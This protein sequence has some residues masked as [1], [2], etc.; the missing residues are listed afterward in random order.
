VVKTAHNTKRHDCV[1]TRDKM[2]Q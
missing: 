1:C 2:N